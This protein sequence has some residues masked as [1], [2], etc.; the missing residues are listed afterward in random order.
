M[1]AWSYRPLEN[2]MSEETGES[3]SKEITMVVKLLKDSQQRE[4]EF[5]EKQHLR[6]LA[7]EQLNWETQTQLNLFR[8]LMEGIQP[9]S[10][11]GMRSDCENARLTKLMDH[12][13]FEVYL[14]TLER[15]FAVYQSEEREMIVPVGT[16]V[17]GK[18]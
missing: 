6:T 1:S 17:F 12:N 16:P 8:Q 7:S 14:M 2:G 3:S 4:T 11:G 18:V 13:G 9:H 5:Q 15:I 10:K